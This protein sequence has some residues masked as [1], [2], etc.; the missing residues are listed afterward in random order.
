MTDAEFIAKLTEKPETHDIFSYA[1][2]HFTHPQWRELSAEPQF[3]S[4]FS[5]LFNEDGHSQS[6]EHYAYFG[7]T[8]IDKELGS[9]LSWFG[10]WDGEYMRLSD[11]EEDFPE[12][13][14]SFWYEGKKYWVLTLEGQGAVSWLLTDEAFRREFMNKERIL[15]GEF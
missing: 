4:W 2:W 7:E 12:H 6:D 5:K 1:H 8:E 10:S 14:T 15:E 11:E 13:A 9:R 3:K